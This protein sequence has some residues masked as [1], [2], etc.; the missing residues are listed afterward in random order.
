MI[1]PNW[2]QASLRKPAGQKIILNRLL[3]DSDAFWVQ[4]VM[5][6]NMGGEREVKKWNCCMKSLHPLQSNINV[7]LLEKFLAVNKQKFNT[8]V[9]LFNW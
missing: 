7:K 4:N 9:T 8:N 5:Y 3:F 1:L 6:R 2:P